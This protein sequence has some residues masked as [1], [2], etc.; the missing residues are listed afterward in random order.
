MTSVASPRK[1]C[2][3]I[4]LDAAGMEVCS[5]PLSNSP[6]IHL[7]LKDAAHKRG[8]QLLS[9]VPGE[10][11][12]LWEAAEISKGRLPTCVSK[13]AMDVKWS[14]LCV[15]RTAAPVSRG[16]TQEQRL[17]EAGRGSGGILQ[18]LQSRQSMLLLQDTAH[19]TPKIHC[20]C[21]LVVHSR[22]LCL[23]PKIKSHLQDPLTVL[24]RLALIL[25]SQVLISNLIWN[26]KYWRISVV[27]L[28]IKAKISFFTNLVKLSLLDHFSSVL[29]RQCALLDH[30]LNETHG[31][32]R[33][34]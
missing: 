22:G 33:A 32:W 8:F 28:A 15:A 27:V 19:G 3:H 18:V 30:N 12:E 34:Y 16:G 17:K 2:A 14:L 26:C 6:S 5:V 9:A 29:I 23:R 4:S 13:K 1:L 7:G 21:W 25:L 10:T 11:D 31:N 20:T 24:W